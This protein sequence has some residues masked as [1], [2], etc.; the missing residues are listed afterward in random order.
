MAALQALHK[1]V[2]QGQTRC[3]Q[4]HIK[5]RSAM[6]RCGHVPHLLQSWQR[7]ISPC[8]VEQLQMI[9]RVIA[10]WPRLQYI[11]KNA[12]CIHERTSQPLKNPERFFT[13][14]NQ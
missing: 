6:A 1:T 12:H 14:G 10:I 3:K 9:V 11:D 13:V 8:K 4:Q 2:S 5:H 7:L